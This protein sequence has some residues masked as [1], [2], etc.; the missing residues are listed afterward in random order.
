[1]IAVRGSPVP[2]PVRQPI[3]RRFRADSEYRSDANRFAS[4]VNQAAN[5][6][7]AAKLSLPAVSCSWQQQQLLKTN[8]GKCSGSH[9]RAEL[10][11]RAH[12]K[13]AFGARA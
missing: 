4:C 10:L 5:E 3:Q 8:S 11:G 13:T 12:I 6:R 1:M 2:L 7:S 9:S